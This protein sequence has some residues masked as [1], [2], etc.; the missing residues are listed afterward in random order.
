MAIDETIKTTQ[1][2]FGEEEEEELYPIK[3]PLVPTFKPPE[4]E[5][6]IK[7]TLELFGEAPPIVTPK[8]PIPPIPTEPRAKELWY[9]HFGRL[10]KSFQK[11]TFG[12]SAR[13]LAALDKASVKLSEVGEKRLGIPKEKLRGGIFG[14][15]AEQH[16]YFYKKLER[17][18]AKGIEDEVLAGLGSATIDIPSIMTFGKYGLPLHGGVMGLAEAGP[19]G[20]ALG[21]LQGALVHKVIQGIG[22]LPSATRLPAWAGFGAVT[23][24]GDIKERT[25][26]AIT[27]SVLGMSGG[28]KKLT[29]REFMANYPKISEKVGE[30][31]ATEM[32]KRLAPEITVEEM[33]RAGGAKVVLDEVVRELHR[34]PE[35]EIKTTKQIGFKATPKEIKTCIK[36][37]DEMIFEAE[38]AVRSELQRQRASLS[39]QLQF[40]EKPVEKR[41]KTYP[42]FPKDAPDI[43]HDIMERGGIARP[44]FE[45]EE[46]ETSVPKQLRRKEGLK[47]DDMSARLGFESEKELYQALEPMRVGVERVAEKPP[48]IIRLEREEFLA[49]Q[50]E[51]EGFIRIEADI[52]K[53]TGY[54]SEDVQKFIEHEFLDGKQLRATVEDVI[55]GKTKRADAVAEIKGLIKSVVGKEAPQPKLFEEKLIERKTVETPTQKELEAEGTGR[56]IIGL[57]LATPVRKA[58]EKIVDTFQIEPQFR[59]AG[60]PETGLAFKAY[61]GRVNMELELAKVAIKRVSKADLT[62]DEFK[63]L[64]F[65]ASRPGKFFPMDKEK[66]TRFSVGYKA[67]RE[68]FDL[69]ADKLKR[70]GI[71][72]EEWPQSAIGRMK[73]T[74]EANMR[75]LQQGKVE[76]ERVPEIKKEIKDLDTALNFLEKTKAQYIH[77]P[78]TWIETF[79]TKKRGDAPKIISE[80]FKQR[81]VYDI[82]KLAKWLVKNK[83]I[84]PEETDIRIIMAQYASKTARKMAL[85]DILNAAT[86]EKLIRDES[87]APEKWQYLDKRMFPTLRG[88]KVSPMFADFMEKNLTARKFM[89]PKLGYVLG[90]IKLLQF[91]NPLFLPMYDT[92]QAWWAGSIRSKYT[93]KSI[94]RAYK[95]MKNK[96]SAYWDANYWGTFSTPFTPNY[97]S[98]MKDVKGMIDKNLF[99][100]S[101]KKYIPNVYRLSWEAAWTG[102]HFIRMITNHHYL[103][104]GFSP[105]DAAQLTA[106][107]HADYAGIPPK[108]RQWINKIFFTP[109]FKI[110]MMAAQMEMIGSAGKQL[111]EAAQIS[112]PTTAKEKAMAKALLGL[113]SGILI[114][115]YIMK[116]LGFSADQWG[117]KYAKEIDTEEGKK[118]IVLHAASP[119]NVYLR[120]YHRFKKLPINPDFVG[121]FVSRA[122]WELHPLWQLGM[123]LVSNQGVAFEPVFNKFD[124]PWKIARDVGVYSTTRILR[125]TEQIKGISSSTKRLEAQRQLS[126]DLGKRLSF[127]LSW[128]TLPYIRSSKERRVQYQISRLI[129]EFKWAEKDKPAKTPEELAKRQEKL[130]GKIRKIQEELKAIK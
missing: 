6:E 32:L 104:K 73:E 48:E 65:V 59:R 53:E 102:D 61:H 42:G 22:L 24:P 69:Y 51:R 33:K 8:T 57:P 44:R 119:D 122:K 43:W 56:A 83:H 58:V 39:E 108:T 21:A 18:G 98:F 12:A 2:L 116:K 26:G 4:K 94:L 52:L 68:F 96:D 111:G 31:R 10:V 125:A 35:P 3:K 19:K 76:V 109:S 86:K 95:S 11:G 118:E 110:S 120:Y 16:E 5:G 27:W 114:R 37:L 117:L 13:I 82:E 20:A 85:K 97:E 1:E 128:F 30:Y 92:F 107:L 50:P 62:K 40:L 60:A 70:K 47:P 123:E 115:N 46:F 121:S 106:K 55:S 80:F 74:R 87:V 126:R 127:V 34:I 77:I 75:N 100:R 91:Y 79:W 41:M 7:S 38:P 112:R 63:E 81:Q 49:K 78:R 105:K 64:T 99:M 124:E 36:Q 72:T 67:V 90:T 28:N 66:R 9:K 103:Q 113:T 101:V 54:K 84:K 17:E 71:L 14:K 130:E 89:P 93:P 129:S 23:T 45:I 15:L 25:A 29:V 88:K